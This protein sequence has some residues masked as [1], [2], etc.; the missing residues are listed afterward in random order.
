MI[1]NNLSNFFQKLANLIEFLVE[2]K[3]PQQLSQ[4]IFFFEKTKQFVQKTNIDIQYNKS[5]SYTLEVKIEA[6]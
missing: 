5:S 1:S 4:T 3:N 2:K 6:K